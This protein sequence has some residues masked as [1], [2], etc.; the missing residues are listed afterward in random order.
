M[1]FQKD[2]SKKKANQ[3][4]RGLDLL[5]RQVNCTALWFVVHMETGNST[6]YYK[7]VTFLNLS[8]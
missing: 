8:F 2:K 4:N 3:S 7:C 5:R 6:N 1:S